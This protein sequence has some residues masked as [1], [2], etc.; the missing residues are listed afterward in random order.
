MESATHP[1]RRQASFRLTED[2]LSELK[3]EAKL[4]NLSLNHLVE[5]ILRAFISERPNATTL[6]AMQEAETS[7]NLETLDV[8]SFRSYVRSL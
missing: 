3:T 4:H 1:I 8:S 6:A 2:L 7:E 5:N